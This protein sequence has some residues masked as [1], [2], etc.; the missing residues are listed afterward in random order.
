MTPVIVLY[1]HPI[2]DTKLMQQDLTGILDEIL[3]SID[4]LNVDYACIFGSVVRQK[5]DPKD[6]DILILSSD[7]QYVPFSK[8]N[9]EIELPQ[10]LA[11]FPIDSWL[12]TPEEF[13]SI[14]S[15]TLMMKSIA[16]NKIEVVNETDILGGKI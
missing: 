12:Y 4:G 1:R 11:G 3:E 9:D 10:K 13:E 2:Y 7:F 6:L 8:R 16:E 14:Y 15:E 5:K